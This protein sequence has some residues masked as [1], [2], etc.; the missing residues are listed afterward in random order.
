M[1]ISLEINLLTVLI[2]SSILLLLQSKR[3]FMMDVHHVSHC[4]FACPECSTYGSIYVS[5]NNDYFRYVTVSLKLFLFGSLLNHR[6]TH[7]DSTI[8]N[9]I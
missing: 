6:V 2:M 5:T 7:S 3:L 9:T 1:L 4:F 8:L